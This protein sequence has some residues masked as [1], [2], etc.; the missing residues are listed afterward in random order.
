MQPKIKGQI[1]WMGQRA[2]R[3]FKRFFKRLTNKQERLKAK[4]DPEVDSGY[5]KHSGYWD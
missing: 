1:E 3:A 5:R 2:A 4:K